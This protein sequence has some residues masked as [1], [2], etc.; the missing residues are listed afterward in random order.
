MVRIFRDLKETETKFA[1]EYD[2]FRRELIVNGKSYRRGDI[3]KRYLEALSQFYDLFRCGEDKYWS[4]RYDLGSKRLSRPISL[5]GNN[6]IQ[7]I[8]VNV[9]IPM[10]LLHFRQNEEEY[11]S[12][13][14]LLYN[15]FPKLQENRVTRFMRHRLFGKQQA[16]LPIESAVAQQGLHQI[17]KDY[18]SKDRG[19][20][21]ECNFQANLK[22]WLEH[23]K[24]EKG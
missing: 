13:L 5:L 4:Y 17:F 22:K 6:R 19:G 9:A 20:C 8:V 11:E 18:C 7:E 21:L 1:P 16:S 15:F 14:Y 24:G 12:T 2:R 3:R 23:R 10:L